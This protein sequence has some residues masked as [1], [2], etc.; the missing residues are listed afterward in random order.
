MKL[1]LPW[2]KDIPLTVLLVILT[3]LTS[4]SSVLVAQEAWISHYTGTENY[5]DGATAIEVDNKGN[6]YVAGYSF[7]TDTSSLI[8]T[9]KYDK[10]GKEKW[11]RHYNSPGRI[12]GA[13]DIAVDKSG[14]VYV[15]GYSYDTD[16]TSYIFTIKYKK[17]GEQQWFKLYSGP[18]IGEN[19]S[20]AIAIDKS[21]KHIYVTGYSFDSDTSSAY[22]TIKYSA[23]GEEEDVVTYKRPGNGQNGAT[24]IAVS[25]DG[26]VYVTGYSYDP[27][28]GFDFTTI[29]YKYNKDDD[30]DDDDSADTL[31]QT[32]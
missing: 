24:A 14:K 13:T 10:K 19:S 20:S 3:L 31:Q 8:V 5:D 17:S 22:V 7:D 6:V 9:I 18:E 32:E 23:R 12:S 21:G 16:T 29:K 28:S 27:N 11:V 15:T 26:N 30:D 25:K 4:A 2:G 1:S